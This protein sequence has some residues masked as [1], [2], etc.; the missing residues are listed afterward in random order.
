M[1]EHDEVEHGSGAPRQRMS[2]RLVVPIAII[3]AVALGL[4][5]ALGVGAVEVASAQRLPLGQ[6]NWC[7]GPGL[8]GGRI[9]NR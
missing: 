9:S 2:R 4:G 1:G 3:S 6:L 8:D 7:V 5:A